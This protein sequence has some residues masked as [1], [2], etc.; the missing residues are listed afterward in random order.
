MVCESS[1]TPL[2]DAI[3]RELLGRLIDGRIERIAE[4]GHAGHLENP[5]AFAQLA[6]HFFL[7]QERTR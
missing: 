5:A 7:E 1:A 4:A 2:T 3:A 6:Q